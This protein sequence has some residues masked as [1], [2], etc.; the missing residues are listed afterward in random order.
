MYQTQD[1]C[2]ATKE[3]TALFS[4]RVVCIDYYITQFPG[5]VLAE[6]GRKVPVIRIFGPN[7]LG[8][9]PIYY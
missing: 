1:D 9:F 4:I 8:T 7:A 5:I 3:N 2:E 6:K